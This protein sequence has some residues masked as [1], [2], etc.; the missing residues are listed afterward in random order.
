MTFNFHVILYTEGLV[1]HFIL[2]ESDFMCFNNNKILILFFAW[3]CLP[4]NLIKEDLLGIH[5]DRM[6]I[7]ASLADVDPMHIDRTVS[8]IKTTKTFLMV[9]FPI[10]MFMK[11]NPCFDLD[12]QCFVIVGI[13]QLI[14]VKMEYNKYWIASFLGAVQCVH[15]P[16]IVCDAG[17]V[18]QH[19]RFEQTHPS[20]EGDGGVSSSL[21][22]SLWE[23][24]NTAP[25]VNTVSVYKP[26]SC[27]VF[28][29]IKMS[30]KTL[31][32]RYKCLNLKLTTYGFKVF[33]TKSKNVLKN[34][35]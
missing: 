9:F 4:M 6:K 20:I 11:I 31:G 21:P 13:L 27:V 29:N 24:Q 7:G 3:R 12:L 30:Q 14:L 32:F 26:K 8:Y 1:R 16:T 10:W 2:T 25:Q 35:V 15:H 33:N 19:R 28:V 22:R 23:V 18:W 5:K 34:W 17:A